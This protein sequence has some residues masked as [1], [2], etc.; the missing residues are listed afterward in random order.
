[1]KRRDFINTT[2]TF[3]ASGGLVV[4]NLG[5]S[6]AKKKFKAEKLRSEDPLITKVTKAMLAMERASWEQGVAAQALL[7]LGETDLVILM[8]K[9]A[10]L[11]QAND[12]RL[13][14]LASNDNVTDPGANG[15]PVLAAART[16]GDSQ[17][18]NAA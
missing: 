18:M 3:T 15:E 4:L 13:A 7:E 6:K 8:A 10:V 5:C 14:D 12:G 1:M 2:F 16:T 17:L 9:E 11:R